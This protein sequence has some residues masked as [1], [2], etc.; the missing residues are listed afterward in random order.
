[1]YHFTYK[2]QTVNQNIEKKFSSGIP[3]ALAKLC[4]LKKGVSRDFLA[5]Y[6]V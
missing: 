1:M 3:G 2:I 6:C 5:K 4:T